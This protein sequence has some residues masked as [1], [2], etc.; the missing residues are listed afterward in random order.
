MSMATNPIKKDGLTNSCI[1][2]LIITILPKCVAFAGMCQK[3]TSSILFTT[4]I[5]IIVIINSILLSL[6]QDASNLSQKYFYIEIVFLIIYVI[7]SLL[8]QI[9]NGLTTSH[10]GYLSDP[11]NILDLIQIIVSIL[12]LF[13]S[14]R[15]ER[16]IIWFR[17]LRPIRIIKIIP[18]LKA[19]VNSVSSSIR[20]MLNVLI[21]LLFVYLLYAVLAVNL[22][23]GIFSRRCRRDSTPSLGVFVIK[24]NITT[25]CGGLVQCENCKSFAEYY[26]TGE[27]LLQE[28]DIKEEQDIEE[29]NY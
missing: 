16:Y 1:S 21:L 5:N 9:S 27:Y 11:W 19:I 23:S 8:K 22:W 4:I 10:H 18:K 24:E 2:F 7:E 12:C 15:N 29:L 3:I 14:L 13:P 17:A 20:E 6:Y 26:D 28:K 25:I